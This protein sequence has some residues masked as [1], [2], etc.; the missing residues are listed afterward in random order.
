M[1]GKL[2]IESTDDEERLIERLA[3]E[4]RSTSRYR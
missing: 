1:A 4:Y 2:Q 3:A